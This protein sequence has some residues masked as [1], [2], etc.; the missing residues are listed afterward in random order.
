MEPQVENDEFVNGF[1]KFV[2]QGAKPAKTA[3][4][5]INI[6][7]SYEKPKKSKLDDFT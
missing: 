4:D 3:K 5:V 7:D 1:Q 6:L 2:E